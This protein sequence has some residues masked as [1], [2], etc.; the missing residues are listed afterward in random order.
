[1]FGNFAYLDE[2]CYSVMII[3]TQ[4]GTI[5]STIT[6]RHIQGLIENTKSC[7]SHQIRHGHKSRDVALADA[8]DCGKRRI[9][10]KKFSRRFLKFVLCMFYMS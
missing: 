5:Y 3:S 10:A 9:Y 7:A 1:M 2:L 6:N 4:T 8:L